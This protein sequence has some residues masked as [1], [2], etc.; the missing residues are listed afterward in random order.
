MHNKT[1]KEKV[2]F[3][4]F[5]VNAQ[6]AGLTTRE[7]SSLLGVPAPTIYAWRH[8]HLRLVEG[9]TFSSPYM[10]GRDVK[11]E[12]VSLKQLLRLWQSA[13]QRLKKLKLDCA[14]NELKF[15][16]K[17]KSRKSIFN[18]ASITAAKRRPRVLTRSSGKSNAS[19]TAS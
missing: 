17:R 19:I 15:L 11:V 7:I 13:P 9:F 6:R 2:I 16:T 12:N 10:V 3:V 8:K 1:P 14:R 18:Q 4:W 5:F